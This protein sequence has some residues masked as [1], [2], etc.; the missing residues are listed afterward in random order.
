MLWLLASLAWGGTT[1]GLIILGDAELEAAGVIEPMAET[2]EWLD[3]GISVVA[4]VVSTADSL[5][6]H[7]EAEPDLGIYD[8]EWVVLVDRAAPMDPDWE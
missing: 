3:I 1:D 5:Q 8:L 6:A 4:T 7:L 2:L